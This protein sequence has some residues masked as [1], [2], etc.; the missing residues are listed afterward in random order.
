MGIDET[1]EVASCQKVIHLKTAQIT[2]CRILWD[3]QESST[4][5]TT[6]NLPS[7]SVTQ[8]TASSQNVTT[9]T[10]SVSS[11]ATSTSS[12]LDNSSSTNKDSSLCTEHSAS[13][14][15]YIDSSLLSILLC[16]SFPFLNTHR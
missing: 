6:L 14:K 10:Q 5:K 4:T 13:T 15:M 1:E 8:V 7:T 12:T 9:T 11:I 3:E 2:Y 16:I